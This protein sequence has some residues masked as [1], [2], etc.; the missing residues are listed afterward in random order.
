MSG[1]VIPASQ[2]PAEGASFILRR[3]RRLALDAISSTKLV[4]LL[5]LWRAKAGDRPMPLR[6]DMNPAD[7][8]PLL[9]RVHMLAV[10]GPGQFRYRLYGSRMA[11]PNRLDMT[12]RTTRE[13]PDQGFAILVTRHLSVTAEEG[14]PAVHLVDG[15]VDGEAYR[16]ERIALPL[17][18]GGAEVAMLMVASERLAIPHDHAPWSAWR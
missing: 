10:E 16:Y 15:E 12:G 8:K 4:S 14:V 11:N 18:V 13:Y 3:E 17:S 5:A 1:V 2:R 7:F 6:S 9:G